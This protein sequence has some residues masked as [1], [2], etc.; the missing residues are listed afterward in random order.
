M[1]LA[2]VAETKNEMLPQYLSWIFSRFRGKNRRKNDCITIVFFWHTH[3]F[4]WFFKF[5]IDFA[6]ILQFCLSINIAIIAYI[7]DYIQHK[8]CLFTFSTKNKMADNHDVDLFLCSVHL[9]IWCCFIH[10]DHVMFII[11]LYHNLCDMSYFVD[12]F[13][14]LCFT[15]YY[16]REWIIHFICHLHCHCHC[17]SDPLASTDERTCG[18]TFMNKQSFKYIKS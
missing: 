11:S 12:A 9:I 16:H 7:I 18:R 15:F 14:N 1:S 10:T 2:T 17:V 3:G 13:N 5:S 4:I 8:I 6:S